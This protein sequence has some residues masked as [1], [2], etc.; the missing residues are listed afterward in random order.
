MKKFGIPLA[1]LIL[2]CAAF[3][4]GYYLRSPDKPI[5]SSLPW[6]K[7]TKQKAP[8][9]WTEWKYP[10]SQERESSKGPRGQ[11]VPVGSVDSVVLTTTDDYEKVLE[12]YAKK[13]EFDIVAEPTGGGSIGKFNT[14]NPDDPFINMAAMPSSFRL[15][16]FKEKSKSQGVKMKAITVR[17]PRYGLVI[18]ISR[19]DHETNTYILI[20]YFPN[21]QSD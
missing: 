7:K 18:N 17:T 11:E 16:D 21:P 8:P 1:I 10:E 13:L 6:N 19:A 15:Q 5:A 12:W 2:M 9:E 14:A 20:T 3:V 4:A